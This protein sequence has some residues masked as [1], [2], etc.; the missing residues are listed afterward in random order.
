MKKSSLS[1]FA[2]A[3][4]VLL[5]A[6]VYAGVRDTAVIKPGKASRPKSGPDGTHARPGQVK[7][8]TQLDER[9]KRSAFK[10]RA[11]E[12]KEKMLATGSGQQDH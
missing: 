5:V 8:G 12:M 4:S 3:L 10:K 6:P 1:M 9:G 7:A 2:I 11:A